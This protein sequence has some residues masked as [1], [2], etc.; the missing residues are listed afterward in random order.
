MNIIPLALVIV[1]VLFSK[2]LDAFGEAI[3]FPFVREV[4]LVG[5]ALFSLKVGPRGPRERN[6]FC[7]PPFT[8]VAVLFAGIFATMAPR[9]GLARG[10]W[11]R[12]G[13]ARSLGST[14]GQQGTIVLFGQRPHLSDFHLVAQ[15]QVGVTTVGDL[16]A[17]AGS[18]WQPSRAGQSSWAPIR[19][20][21][22]R[23]TSPS[24]ASLSARASRCPFFGYMGYSVAVLIPIFA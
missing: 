20:S 21:A 14:S 7:W 12:N 18:C 17:S 15:G 1:A 10:A 13:L 8:E 23:P 5:L 9:P 2:E 3:H 16:S 19:T 6:A 22:M 24:S 11:V 4:I